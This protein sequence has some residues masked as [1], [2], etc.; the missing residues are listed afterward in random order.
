MLND[1]EQDFMRNFDETVYRIVDDFEFVG[2]EVKIEW[3][4]TNL[5]IS[6]LKEIVKPINFRSFE[7]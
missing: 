2:H 7:I 6:M 4:R 5:R 1:I 3:L